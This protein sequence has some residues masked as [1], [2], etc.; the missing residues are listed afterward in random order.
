MRRAILAVPAVLAVL[1]AS[2]VAVSATAA[3][4]E[5][6]DVLEF[7][8]MATVTAPFTGASDPV[9]GVPGGGLPWQIRRADGELRGDGRLELR[10]EGLV[11]ARRAP[12]PPAQQGT[13]PIPQFRAIV[14]CLTPGNGGTAADTVD[15]TTDPV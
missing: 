2:A 10:V 12:V 3:S 13:N 6:E 15:R 5:S 14:S 1:A 8:S 4:S 7:D 11:L 9:R